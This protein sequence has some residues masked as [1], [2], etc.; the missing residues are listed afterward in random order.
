MHGASSRGGWVELSTYLF[1]R[2]R[3]ILCKIRSESYFKQIGHVGA[4]IYLVAILGKLKLCKVVYLG[5]F[6]KF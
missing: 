4:A 2:R 3:D 5:C 6:N 1:L